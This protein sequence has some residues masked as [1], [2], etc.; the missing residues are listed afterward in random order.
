MNSTQ[1]QYSGEVQVG[2]PPQPFRVIFD[3]GSAWLWVPT[4]NCPRCI[5][6]RRFNSTQSTTYLSNGERVVL[7]YG[8]GSCT[9]RNSTDRVEIGGLKAEGQ[10][11]VA[12]SS[13]YE[14]EGTAADGIL[15]RPTQGLGYMALS[16]NVPTLMDSLYNQGAIPAKVLGV[17]LSDS[18]DRNSASSSVSIGDYDPSPFAKG[19]L[20]FTPNIYPKVGFWSVNLKAVSFGAVSLKLETHIAIFDTGASLIA[21]AVSDFSTVSTWFATK[22]G[23]EVKNSYIACDCSA[24]PISVFPNITFNIG[25]FEAQLTGSQYLSAYRS[26]GQLICMVLITSSFQDFWILG[27]PFLRQFYT[28]YDMD[29]N[30][31]GFASLS[32]EPEA[33]F[34]STWLALSG[35]TVI[36]L[37]VLGGILCCCLVCRKKKPTEN[38][39]Y[40]RMPES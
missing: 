25:G 23:C 10:A 15:V 19:T 13:E 28:V 6:T 1:T 17:F 40:V 4:V 7:K 20:H 18:E 22:F 27:D 33:P 30:Q 3:T 12:V 32:E 9:G 16:S 29:N 14:L 36:M 37:T 38:D 26:S 35:A 11:F 39:V 21:A 31:I 34:I 2:S 24:H 5:G 8:S